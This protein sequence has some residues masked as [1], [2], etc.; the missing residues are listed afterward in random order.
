MKRLLAPLSI[1]N[2]VAMLMI[3]LGILGI[4]GM[5]ISAWMSR[6]S[7]VVLLVLVVA[8]LLLWSMSRTA[9]KITPANYAKI[10][11]GL[12]EDEVNAVLGSPAGHTPL[13]EA[14]FNGDLALVR[15][16]LES[17][18]DRSV[19]T[20]EGETALEIAVKHGR[21]EAARLLEG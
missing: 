5:G 9:R 12:T 2:Q 13:H 17:G 7:S 18:A 14:A 6:P 19:R 3:L 1:V 16:L 11:T 15:L 4:A 21:H 20:G 10:T 8:G